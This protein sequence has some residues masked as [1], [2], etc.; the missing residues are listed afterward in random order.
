[1]RS[2][3]QPYRR[4]TA[5]PPGDHA[6]ILK[7]RSRIRR[8]GHSPTA[9]TAAAVPSVPSASPPAPG[10]TRR[11]R[12]RR[13]LRRC[14]RRHASHAGCHSAETGRTRAR[15]GEPKPMSWTHCA[16]EK[17]SGHTDTAMRTL[18]VRIAPYARRA[19]IQGSAGPSARCMRTYIYIHPCIRTWRIA[20]T[21]CQAGGHGT[22][23]D[24]LRRPTTA[25]EITDGC[26]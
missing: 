7:V 4:H 13:S 10:L 15:R 9:Q 12:R 23:H 17:R 11:S 2:T 14:R 6:R 19:A 3:Q 22:C 21:S 18:S 1:M 20:G 26:R 16:L 8:R 5:R 24:P 25:P